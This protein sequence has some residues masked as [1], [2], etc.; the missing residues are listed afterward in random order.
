[1]TQYC[2]ANPNPKPDSII[3][4]LLYCCNRIIFGKKGATQAIALAYDMIQVGRAERVI[5]VAG[6]SA[7]SDNLM[8]WLGNGFRIL[9]AACISADP[10]TA[11]RP[12]SQQRSGMILGSGGIGMILES[13][14]GAR[15]RHLHDLTVAAEAA[16][17]ATASASASAS[18]AELTASAD[19]KTSP[20]PPPPSLPSLP[21]LP[22]RAAFRCRLLGTL[23]SN[24]AYHGAAM[25]R[26]HIA[27]EMERFIAA[28]EREQG[29]S[30]AD[31][32]KHGVYFSHETGTHASPSSSCAANEVIEQ[33]F[34]PAVMR[35]EVEVTPVFIVSG[36]MFSAIF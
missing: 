35:Y 29:I 30:R 19:V 4:S 13:E 25:D 6:D 9:G 7:S 20:P 31:I 10:K 22:S 17:A 23:V 21:S 3:H 16:A 12:F 26:M 33:I 8:P 5:V 34:I 24:S 36:S 15:R 2:N 28:V 27:E 18:A 11:A 14:D 1:M 32:A